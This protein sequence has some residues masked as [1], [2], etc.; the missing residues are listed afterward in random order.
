MVQQEGG[1]AGG[2]RRH[3]IRLDISR[4]ASLLFR[5][6]GVDVT[7]GD[8]IAN[9][10]GLSTRTIWRH[11]RSKES[12]AE[13]IFARGMDWEMFS[14]R[15]WPPELSLDDHFVSSSLKYAR[16]ITDAQRA[17][18]LLASQMIRLAHREPA[19]RAVWLTAC[20]DM[21]REMAEIFERRIIAPADRIEIRMFASMACGVIRVMR[22]EV[23]ERVLSSGSEHQLKDAASRIACAV[24]R[25]TGGAIG[26]PVISK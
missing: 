2:P 23:G 22:E 6:Q 5:E 11:F 12:C 17:D 7:S 24:R 26:D 19:L 9:A 18:D 15:S 3:R 8:Q 21:E 20:D 16:G 1:Q 10:A 4:K 14:L 25:A 13:P